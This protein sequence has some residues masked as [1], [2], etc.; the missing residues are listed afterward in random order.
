[1]NVFKSGTGLKPTVLLGASS[2]HNG[3]VNQRKG[4]A[5][6]WVTGNLH[7]VLY[8]VNRDNYVPN[9]QMHS[10]SIGVKVQCGHVNTIV[11]DLNKL[12]T[13]KCLILRIII[14]QGGPISL[15]N[16]IKKYMT[17][18]INIAKDP[19]KIFFCKNSRAMYKNSDERIEIH[20]PP[21]KFLGGTERWTI[22]SYNFLQDEFNLSICHLHLSI[23]LRIV[24]RE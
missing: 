19:R 3:H 9:L 1:M 14:D 20:K 24:G 12:R 22:M 16:S 11:E 7:V 10:K 15:P 17:I 18:P 8:H 13:V 2:T 6:M 21:P 23:R 4:L 5:V